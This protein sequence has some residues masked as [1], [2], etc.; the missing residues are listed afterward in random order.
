ME[1]LIICLQIFFARIMDVS[2]GTVRT[3]LVVK[4]KTILA[5]LIAFVEIFI[6]FVIAKEALN[7][8][9]QS[10]WIAISYS[11]GFA[12]G[13]FIGSILSEKFIEGQLTVQ[14]ITS[15]ANFE[16]INN[17]RKAGYGVTVIDVKGHDESK[18]KKMLF[19]EIN[20]RKLGL[21][22]KL[23]KESDDKAFIVVNESKHVQNGY[24]ATK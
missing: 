10:L 16:I 1:I 12:S 13:T 14:V 2:L 19:I 9:I 3:I 21:L 6:W 15:D 11:A 7:T 5:S 17:L 18:D 23:I 4:G 24:F 22:T 20:K 8:E